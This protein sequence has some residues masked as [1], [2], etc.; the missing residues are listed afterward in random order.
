MIPV[1]FDLDGTLIDSLP[2]ITLAANDLL[3]AHDLPPLEATQ[4]A[5]FVGHGEIAFLQRLIAATDLNPEKFDAILP[6]FIYRYK[7]AAKQTRMMPGARQALDT[8]KEQGVPIGLCTNKPRAALIPTLAAVGLS[9]TFDTVVAGTDHEKRKPD[10]ALLHLAMTGL[11]AGRCIYVGDSEVDAETAERAA[12]PFLLYTKGIRVTPV[13][14]IP[15]DAAFDDFAGLAALC[16]RV[17]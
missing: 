7:A 9:G 13:A 14:D 6:D 15:H 10:P 2:D 3:A 16:A 1:I 12:V 4:V 5:G 17:S 8:L 11:G